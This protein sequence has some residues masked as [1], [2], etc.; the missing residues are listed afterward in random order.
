MSKMNSRTA[1]MVQ[2]AARYYGYK[3]PLEPGMVHLIEEEGFV[4]GNYKDDVGITTA[5]VGQT[6]ENIGK[7]FFTE[8]YP[9]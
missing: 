7:N 9:D 5:G 8:T 2:E 1:K 6:E 3:G 4:A